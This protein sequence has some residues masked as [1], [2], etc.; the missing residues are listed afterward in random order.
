MPHWKQ[1][2]T[3]FF[4]LKDPAIE[5]VLKKQDGKCAI[6]KEYMGKREG[7]YKE[8]IIVILKPH[9]ITFFHLYYNQKKYKVKQTSKYALSK[10]EYIC[11]E[12]QKE[13]Y[14]SGAYQIICKKCKRKLIDS[15]QAKKFLI[16]HGK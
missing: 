13:L 2:Y 10:D 9:P 7:V 16:V 15:F 4:S 14:K 8:D 1:K 6:C 3:R 12:M 11:K 5:S